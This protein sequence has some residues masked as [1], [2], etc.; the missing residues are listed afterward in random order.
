MRT[1]RHNDRSDIL[2]AWSP[3]VGRLSL[4]M[5][6]GR[7]KE[8][9]RRRALTMPLSMFEVVVDVKG[10]NELLRP[11]EIRA[12]SPS[13]RAADV[14]SHPVRAA[15]SMFIAEALSAVTREGDADPAL[16]SLVVETVDAVANGSANALAN[17]P[18][19]FLL[20]LA[21]VSGI[22]PDTHSY[23]PGM[24]FDMVEGVFR[25]S[26]PLHDYRIGAEE[27]A[28]AMKAAGILGSYSHLGLVRLPRAVRSRMLD[29]MLRYFALH[30][31]PL[32]RLRSPDV[33]KA[34]FR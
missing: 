34:V 19:A 5:G 31:F 32:D 14:T 4:V 18:V 9:L 30:H 15:V 26:R 10:S 7:S 2:T 21:A 22:E 20:R 27:L 6:A 24:E 11:R 29:D 13:G 1:V 33:L 8:S 12:W 25:T 17:L 16:W 23:R 3:R 28:V